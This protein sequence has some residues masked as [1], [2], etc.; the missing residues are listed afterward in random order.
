MAAPT[1]DTVSYS[2]LLRKPTEAIG[3]LARSRRHTLR[4]SRRDGEDLVLTTASR[5]D[6]DAEVMH[7]ATGLLSAIVSDPA[8]RSKHAL[9]LMRKVIPWV[10]FLPVDDLEAFLAELTDVAT[11]SEALGTTMPVATT[12]QA[13]KAT[14][15]AYADPEVAEALE[16]G[17]TGDY[18]PVPEPE[19]KTTKAKLKPTRAQRRAR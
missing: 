11:A 5:A 13:W 15:E 10:R 12:I 9:D 1:S 14:A 2:D 16:R 8:I 7:V 18:G 19:S 4:V 3:K 6:A 17:V